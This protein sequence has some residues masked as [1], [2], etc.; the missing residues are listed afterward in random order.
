[1]LLSL[2]TQSSGGVFNS[3]L[4]A[5]QWYATVQNSYLLANNLTVN[6]SQPLLQANFSEVKVIFEL[7]SLLINVLGDI[8][9]LTV[10]KHNMITFL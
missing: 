4:M 10:H 2:N 5:D 7:Y 8:Q 9:K 1:M 3:S 6:T